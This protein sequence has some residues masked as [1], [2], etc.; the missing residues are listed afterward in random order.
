MINGP[1]L[2]VSHCS[3]PRSATVRPVGTLEPTASSL[4]VIDLLPMMRADVELRLPPQERAAAGHAARGSQSREAEEE[5]Q[6]VQA[7]VQRTGRA[8]KP[9]LRGARSRNPKSGFG[10][11]SS[12][13]VEP[14]CVELAPRRARCQSRA[15]GLTVAHDRLRADR[16]CALCT[17][18]TLVRKTRRPPAGGT[19][20]SSAVARPG[21]RS[22]FA[23]RVRSECAV[24]APRDRLRLR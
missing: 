16:L 5:R 24:L 18:G 22:S 15:V 12:V 3:D 9:S 20:W 11:E 21:C 14:V 10:G 2:V 8:A 6:Q 1:R 13:D 17:A 7:A 4:I 23:P 19:A